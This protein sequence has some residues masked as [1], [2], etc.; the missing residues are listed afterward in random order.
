[1]K[2]II[3]LLLSLILV[4]CNRDNPTSPVDE[5]NQSYLGNNNTQRVYQTIE[6]MF[7]P[8]SGIPYIKIPDSLYSKLSFNTIIQENLISS[9]TPAACSAG[10]T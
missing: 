10:N 2:K 5:L 3:F 6:W 1:M 8:N 4:R 7:E 9:F